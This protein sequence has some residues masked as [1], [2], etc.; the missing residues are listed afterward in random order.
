M[1][2][3]IRQACLQAA[4]LSESGFFY[5]SQLSHGVAMGLRLLVFL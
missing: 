1:L 5:G 4:F 2:G 3:G